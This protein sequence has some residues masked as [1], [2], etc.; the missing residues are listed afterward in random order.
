MYKIKIPTAGQDA[1]A[2]FLVD[3]ICLGYPNFDEKI[4]V[5]YKPGFACTLRLEMLCNIQG[6]RPL[7]PFIRDL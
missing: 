2:Q 5:G 1:K 7:R 3:G 6:Y 4:G